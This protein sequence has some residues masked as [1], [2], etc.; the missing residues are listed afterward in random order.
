MKLGVI[1][2]L[3]FEARPSRQRSWINPYD[4]ANLLARLTDALA[5]F[6]DETVDAV[7]LVGDVVEVAGEAAFDA[8]FSAITLAGLPTAMVAGNHDWTAD[9]LAQRK[10]AEHSI[11]FLGEARRYGDFDL[12]G[13]VARPLPRRVYCSEACSI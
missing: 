9:D 10:A 11:D 8:A 6:V 4:A 2:D 7:V 12:S 3:H 5:W 13:V 1:S